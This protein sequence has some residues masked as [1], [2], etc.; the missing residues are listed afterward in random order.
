MEFYEI[1]KIKAEY[2]GQIIQRRTQTT[3]IIF[4]ID[5]SSIEEWEF[6]FNNGFEFVFEL[7]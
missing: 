1:Y 5:N 2:I 4:D 3:L 6:Y 7:K